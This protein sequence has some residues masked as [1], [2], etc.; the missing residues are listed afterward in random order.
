[1]YKKIS[2]GLLLCFMLSACA[3]QVHRGVIAMKI[4]EDTQR[5]RRRWNEAMMQE[6]NKFRMRLRQIKA[7]NEKSTYVSTRDFS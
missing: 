7:W 3:S 5:E 4:D 1:M 6:I 2:L